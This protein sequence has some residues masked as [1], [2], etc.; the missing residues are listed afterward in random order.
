M[1]CGLHV[2]IVAGG[3]YSCLDGFYFLIFDNDN[4]L[5]KPPPY[6]HSNVNIF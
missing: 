3:K 4:H 5:I 2:K 6:D 1:K